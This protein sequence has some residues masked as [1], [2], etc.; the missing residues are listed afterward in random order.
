MKYVVI[1]ILYITL[2]GSKAE[3]SIVI[4]FKA[5][6]WCNDSVGWSFMAKMIDLD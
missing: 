1:H 2:K 6:R 3:V 4:Y 5:F